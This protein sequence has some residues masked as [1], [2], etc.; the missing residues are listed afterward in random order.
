M[1]E[2]IAEIMNLIPDLGGKLDFLSVLCIQASDEIMFI[3]EELREEIC[4]AERE[5][6][7]ANFIDIADDT[8]CDLDIEDA[9]LL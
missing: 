7:D 6:L 4:Q 5:S 2:K 1:K 3:C 8:S 9:D